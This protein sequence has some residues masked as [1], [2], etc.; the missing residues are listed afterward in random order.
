MKLLDDFLF[1]AIKKEQ[2]QLYLKTF[3]KLCRILGIPVAMEKTS[4]ELLQRLV[5]LGI[6]L[7]TIKMLAQLPI[8]KLVSYTEVFKI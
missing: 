5:F 2:C 1:L 7:D 4:E 6:L 3:L 8:N